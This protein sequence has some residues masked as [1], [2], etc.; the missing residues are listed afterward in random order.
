MPKAKIY[1][2][3][4]EEQGEMELSEAVFG[5]TDTQ[6]AVFAAVKAHL[7]ARRSGTQSALTRSE[8]E[9]GGAKPWRQK[10]TGRARH[11]STRAPQWKSGG[12]AFAPKPRDYRY[13]LNKK[14]KRQAMRGA[15][16]AKAESGGIK[17]IDSL[18]LPEIKTKAFAAFLSALG[19]SGKALVV[20]PEVR[21]AVVRSARNI[22]GVTTTLSSTLC[23]YDILNHDAFIADKAALAHIEEVFG[24]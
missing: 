21:E 15:L 18:E 11:G 23:V 9:G 16:T 2:M 4:G 20:T 1:N 19:V 10:G 24:A 12:A 13:R 6:N 14:I 5:A 3:A 22:P 17:V 8:V 7:A